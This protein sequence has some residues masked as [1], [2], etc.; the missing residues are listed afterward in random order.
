VD[1]ATVVHQ[2]TQLPGNE[3]TCPGPGSYDTGNWS[4]RCGMQAALV[5]HDRR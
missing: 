1:A 4:G 5:D 2:A 3:L